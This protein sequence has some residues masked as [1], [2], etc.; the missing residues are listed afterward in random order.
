MDVAQLDRY[1]GDADEEDKE[2]IARYMKMDEAQKACFR[3]FGEI[4]LGEEELT[5]GFVKEFNEAFRAYNNPVTLEHMKK[6]V[7]AA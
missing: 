6:Y 7:K 3:K 4:V 1:F 5:M 2:F